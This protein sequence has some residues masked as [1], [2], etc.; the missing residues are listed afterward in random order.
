MQ[1]DTIAAI[2]Q[3]GEGSKP[4]SIKFSRG[5]SVLVQRPPA[6]QWAVLWLVAQIGKLREVR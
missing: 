2:R 6:A 3:I 4:V 5:S 1:Y